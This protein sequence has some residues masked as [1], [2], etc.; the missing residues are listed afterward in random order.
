MHTAVVDLDAV[1]GK[2]GAVVGDVR[3]EEDVARAVDGAV[4]RFGGFDICLN[5]SSAIAVAPTEQLSAK[6]FGLM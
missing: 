5:N 3:K 1:D 2:A 4:Q 6:K